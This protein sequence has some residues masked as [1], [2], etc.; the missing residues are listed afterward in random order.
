MWSLSDKHTRSCPPS[1]VSFQ[2]IVSPLFVAGDVQ[3]VVAFE[4][5]KERAVLTPCSC[6]S[7]LPSCPPTRVH[8]LSARLRAPGVLLGLLSYEPSGCWFSAIIYRT[9]SLS[10][11]FCAEYRILDRQT[12]FQFL[13]S[14]ASRSCFVSHES[15]A[16]LL[17]SFSCSQWVFPTCC[18]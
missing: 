16:A 15:L 12:Y 10:P 14:I 7:A 8:P 6:V 3:T 2:Q 17:A 5:R 4:V 11:L 18:F 9:M 13:P 1:R